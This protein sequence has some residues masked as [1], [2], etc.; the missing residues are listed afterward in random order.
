MHKEK[1]RKSFIT[2]VKNISFIIGYCC[3]NC[4]I[5]IIGIFVLALLSGI[6][7]A[8]VILFYKYALESLRGDNPFFLLLVTLSIYLFIQLIN[9]IMRNWLSNVNFPIWDMKIKNGISKMLYSKYVSIDL[10]DMDNSE[11]Y[12]KYVRAL[13]E[14]DQRSV[15][16]LNTLQYFL[17]NLFSALG[18]L[19]VVAI[20]DPILI[21]FSVIPVIT[22]FFI[23]IR[24][25]K[26]RYDYEMA[27]T[28]EN[29]KI[30]Y[31][32]RIFVLPQFREEIRTQDYS[33]LLFGKY[34]YSNGQIINTIKS[35][36]PSIIN[37]SVFG[38]NLFSLMNY[39]IPAVYLGWQVINKLISIGDFSALLIGT[40]NLSSSIFYMAIL[41]PQMVQH[42]L[43]IDN[44]REILDYKSP[45]EPTEESKVV[46]KAQSHSIILDNVSFKYR[47]SES[48]I[49]KNISLRINKGE[50]I[51]LVGENGAG[52]STLVK[53]MLRLYDP[54]RGSLYFDDENYTKLDVESLRKEIAIVYQDFQ[55]FA[56]SIGEN[57][58]ARELRGEKD[59]HD[60]WEALKGSGLSGKVESLPDKLN[61]PLTNEFEENGTNFSGGESQ[62]LAI[63]KAV[64]KDAGVVIMDEPSS[65]LDPKSE[66]EMYMR[67]FAMCKDKTL[68]LI[69][70]RLYSTKMVDKIYYMES[71]SILES[72]SHEELIKQNGKYAALYNI[73]AGQYK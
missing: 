72:G 49:I 9:A 17:S 27:L 23:N 15:Q 51:A 44:L 62:K 45:M 3:K 73:Q 18:V 10:S 71:G 32:K 54:Q 42:S 34:L 68:I 25:N 53:L 52:K 22:S 5:R 21:F 16:V 20:L 19:S 7:A 37:K 70:H 60:V 26:E 59:E 33:K 4:K 43:F 46:Q 41:V 13:N 48:D 56:F 36:M 50:K 24:I 6:N 69:S 67:M 66:H 12:D 63:A 39:G 64:Y 38:A 29:R 14:A 31:I 57:V 61:T 65:S 40:A 8:N 2:I 30:S 47:S 11:F 28:K 55:S 58:I 1:A 35:R